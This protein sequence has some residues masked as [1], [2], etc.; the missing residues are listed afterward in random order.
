[1][2]RAVV[3][4][5]NGTIID[6]TKMNEISWVETINIISNNQLNGEEIFYKNN[7]L[8]NNLMIEDVL[9]NPIFL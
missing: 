1:M 9:K 3:F 7:G 2:I 5:Y 4:D 8:R 6:D